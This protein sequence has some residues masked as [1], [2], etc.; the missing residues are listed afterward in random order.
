MEWQTSSPPPWDNFKK[1]P[2]VRDPYDFDH[3]VYDEKSQGYVTA[4]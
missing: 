1:P 4:P 3:L 2:E